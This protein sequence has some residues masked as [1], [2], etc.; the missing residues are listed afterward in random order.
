MM[1][2][3]CLDESTVVAFLAGSLPTAERSAVESHLGACAACAE[4]TT[5]AAA[6][7]AQRSRPAG[8]EGRPFIGA[9][10]P[11]DRVDCYQ[12]LGAVGRGGMG[13]VYAA[14]HPDL[15]RRIALKVVHELGA[16]APEH[17]ARLLREA[18]AIARLSHPNVVSVHDAGTVGDRVYIAMEFVDGE[19][20]DTWLRRKPRE[21]RE[22]VDVFI[23]AGRG[24]AAAH[25]AGVVHRDF[26]PQNVMVGSDGSV[27]VMDF[28]LARMA[29]EPIDVRETRDTVAERQ[30]S[31]A[32]T[33][34]GA[35]VGTPAYMAPEQFRG[36]SVDARADQFSFCVAVFEAL[37]ERRPHLPHLKET[38]T[39]LGGDA[40]PSLKRASTPGWLSA[41]L[42]RDL[43]VD[44]ERRFPS[45][46]SLL[47]SMTRGRMRVRHR[48]SILTV[49]LA[50][51]LLSFGGWRFASARRVSCA[52]PK[53]RLARIWSAPSDSP[54]RI[55]LHRAFTASG[56]A[57]GET[58]WQ[59]VAQSL[60]AYIG[61]WSAMYVETCEAT[62]VR[63]EQSADVLDLRMSCLNDNLD[64]V[65][66]LTD[67]LSAADSATLG[68]AVT[69]TQSLPPV[70]L[71]ADV[72]SLRSAVPP[73]R[74]PRTLEAVR[75]LRSALR[76]AE[77]VRDLANFEAA[78]AHAI[79]L[80]S[81][82]ETTGYL[83][84]FA[85][86]LELIGC[87]SA[88]DG[89]PEDTEATLLQ[90]LFVAEAARDDA[91]AAKAAANL[92][93]IV[94][95]R[96]KKPREAETWLRLSNS[97]L[98]RIG[99]GD[100]RTRAWATHNFAY[101]LWFTGDFERA[102]LFVR[103]AI[104]LKEQA[105]GKE[106][107]DVAISLDVASVILRELGRNTEA[108]QYADRSLDIL[109]KNGDSDSDFIANSRMTRGEALVALGRG[110]EAETSFATGLKVVVR[111][112]GTQSRQTA[113]GLQG[114]GDSKLVQ[115]EPADAIPYLR[116]ALRIRETSA[117]PDVLLAET[118]FSLARAL[119]ESGRDKKHALQLAKRAKD[120]LVPLN[121]PRRK[122]T[123]ARWL[124]DHGAS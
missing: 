10:A 106:H 72:R 96:L 25:A 108:L 85:E 66:A 2:T 110:Q 30:R 99:P 100:K 71:C 92:I 63:G 69:A 77:A 68:Q 120:A 81:R 33:K 79:S 31:A 32:V 65:R 88:P 13:E 38:N 74:D 76:D 16:D 7:L 43:S 90:A 54:K 80:R 101:V 67:V 102:E 24:L 112:L 75:G 35:L 37:H 70:S 62:H 114:L 18:R 122:R 40:P 17:R 50:T 4:L 84:L 113:F 109:I 14:Y 3:A 19:T 29:Q 94:G 27:R 78:R 26:K 89:R 107:P 12:V 119:W 5:W 83:P 56:R 44:R 11:G 105:L 60:D 118:R 1:A 8:A 91:T 51:A 115:G 97:I 57:T 39:D 53:D 98:D 93:Y 22:I 20:V 58:S 45:M 116:D 121:F 59:R 55:A 47:I 104:T 6:D 41:A 48:T 61:Q 124:A 34:T 103:D 28:G 52:P 15:D 46:E 21:W 23:A 42:N 123:V 117:E 111:E 36:E 87:T 86:L 49:A 82:V 9:L 95:V 64:Q 73:P